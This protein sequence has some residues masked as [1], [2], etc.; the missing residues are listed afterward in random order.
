MPIGIELSELVLQRITRAHKATTVV[1]VR[2]TDRSREE[3][4]NWTEGARVARLPPSLVVPIWR[5]MSRRAAY[6]A[7]RACG[8]V[9]CIQTVQLMNR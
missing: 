5:I 1:D 6:F 8:L 3:A 9:T 4:I 7:E 2:G